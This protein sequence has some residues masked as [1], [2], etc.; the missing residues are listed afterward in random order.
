M[1]RVS[2]FVNLREKFS[3]GPGFEPGSPALRTGASTNRAIQILWVAQ[4]VRTPAC[5][6]ADQ[7]LN[8]G[9]GENFSLKLTT[10]GYSE[11][12]NFSQFPLSFTIFFI[13]D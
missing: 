12:L 5:K 13:N 6:A 10:E 1:A 8:P 4:L 2:S 3:P 7:G 9:L 11:K